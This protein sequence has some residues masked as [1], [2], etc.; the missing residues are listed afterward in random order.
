MSA[1]PYDKSSLQPSGIALR[2][3]RRV[4]LVALTFLIGCALVLWGIVV[5]NRD[6]KA[7]ALLAAVGKNDVPM[8]MRL[9]AEG[10]DPNMREPYASL[11]DRLSALFRL[12]ESRERETVFCQRTALMLLIAPSYAYQVSPTHLPSLPLFRALLDHHADPNAPVNDTLPLEAC[13][14]NIPD[15]A[16][17]ALLLAHG[18]KVEGTDSDGMTALM[19]ACYAQN[20]PVAR[21]LIAQRAS[22]TVTDNAGRTPLHWAA[23]FSTSGPHSNLAAIPGELL[24]RGA[25]INAQDDEGETPL[26]RAIEN[27]QLETITALLANHADTN[28]VNSHGDTP[29]SLAV[30]SAQNDAERRRYCMLLLTHGANID[31]VVPHCRTALMNAC[32]MH[33]APMVRFL[34][35]HGASVT[36]SDNAGCTPLH[37]AM[38]GDTNSLPHFAAIYAELL[39]RGADINARD[40]D[41]ETPLMY[42][43]NYNLPNMVKILLAHHADADLIDKQGET[44]L[45]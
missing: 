32:Q 7:A 3:T 16:Y 20:V 13:A 12:T 14:G 34:L 26:M 8:A 27:N 23:K 17:C 40:H 41:G 11:T 24:R 4:R 15:P 2:P 5:W 44:A 38:S 28:L 1:P 31:G 19:A 42:A 6:T 39:A 37:W 45:S 10:A 29:L 30:Q 33:D 9:L 43:V 18:A 21:F 25:D 22:V 36:A 35:A